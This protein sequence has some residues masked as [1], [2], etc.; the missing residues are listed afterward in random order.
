MDTLVGEKGPDISY[1]GVE[2]FEE[3]TYQDRGIV[4]YKVGSAMTGLPGVGQAA[5]TQ[6]CFR[7]DNIIGLY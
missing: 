1:V 7:S 2:G 3:K 5:D 4:G 6:K